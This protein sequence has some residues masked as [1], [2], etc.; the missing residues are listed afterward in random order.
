[1]HSLTQLK[2]LGP[3]STQWLNAI[4]VYTLDDLR[5]MGAIDCCRI[6]KAQGYPVSLNLAYAIEG[7]LRDL[8]WTKLPESVKQQLKTALQSK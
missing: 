8:H 6:L 4:G 5:E 1:M 7:A 3:K 2:N